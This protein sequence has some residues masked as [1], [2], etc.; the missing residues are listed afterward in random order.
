MRPQSTHN[1]DAHRNPRAPSASDWVSDVI[2][3]PAL[4]QWLLVL[5]N[6]RDETADFVTT[7][8][9]QLD[10]PFV[11]L[12]TDRLADTMALTATQTCSRLVLEGESY[13]SDSFSHVWLRR[14]QP[15]VIRLSSDPAENLHIQQEWSAAIEGLLARIPRRRWI[16]HPAANAAASYKIEQLF[17]A[18]SMGLCVP[19]TLVTQSSEEAERFYHSH[20]GDI[21]VKPITGGYIERQNPGAD[22]VIYT[23][24]VPWEKLSL[25]STCNVC[26][27]LLQ[28]RINKKQDVRVI[29]VD[30]DMHAVALTSAN[31]K[32]GQPIDI[33]ANNFADVVYDPIKLPSKIESQI[34]DYVQSYELRFAAID[35][36]LNDHD[37]WIFFELNP[38]GQWAWLELAG[39]A[40]I[41][42]SF[43]RT[44]RRCDDI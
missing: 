29:I 44:F 19:D 11:R 14:P 35:M 1:R 9:Q 20:N 37:D 26:P 7:K 36:A 22:T 3:S 12:N 6:S 28:E 18:R 25:F 17:R 33:R 5:T 38:N 4:K 42:E 16:N 34:R 39:A 43:V 13:S 15:L 24:A 2:F 41:A 32:T 21:V 30:K 40:H 8:L 10:F 27:V 31:A 23:Q